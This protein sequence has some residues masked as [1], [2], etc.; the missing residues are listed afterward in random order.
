M[1]TASVEMDP[2][3]GDD[4]GMGIEFAYLLP[5]KAMAL[6][7]VLASSKRWTQLSCALG[8]ARSTQMVHCGS[9]IPRQS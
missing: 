1:V 9:W 7:Y 5:P 3:L 6:H 8:W 4:T 2:T